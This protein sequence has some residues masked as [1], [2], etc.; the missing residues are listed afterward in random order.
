MLP[1]TGMDLGDDMKHY[2]ASERGHG[3][4][5]KRSLA[6]YLLVSLIG[7]AAFSL[8]VRVLFVS[9]HSDDS[10]TYYRLDDR[11]VREPTFYSGRWLMEN[12]ERG[13]TFDRLVWTA[14]QV[15]AG[16]FIFVERR[17]KR[18]VFTSGSREYA[19]I[20][21]RMRGLHVHD[22]DTIYFLNVDSGYGAVSKDGSMVLSF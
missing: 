5:A 16:P 22:F 7:L 1:I 14:I 13:V 18:E 11:I 6:N 4:I 12:V 19:T 15:S 17:M 21:R 10:V 3:F 2:D 9:K 8:A 20:H